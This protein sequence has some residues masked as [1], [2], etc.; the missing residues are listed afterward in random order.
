MFSVCKWN[1][2][3]SFS[4][5]VISGVRQ[6]GVLSAKFW[7]I[8]MND[9]FLKL[10]S[11]LKGCHILNHFLACIL[12][13]DDVC[14]L[15]PTRKAMQRLLD[16]CS[17]YAQSWCIKYN[18][19]KTKMMYFGDDYNTLTCGPLYL[20]GKNLEFVTEWK[21]LGVMVMSNKNFCTSVLKP[22]CAFYRSSNSILNV[23]HGPSEDVQM[24]LLY[25]ICVP[26]IT[27]ACDVVEY[28]SKDKMSLHVALNDA[29]RKIFGYDRWQ[30]IKDI[31]ESFGFPSITEI[32]AKRKSNFELYLPHTGN[33]LLTFLLKI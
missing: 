28:S 11:T 16:I 32:F 19:N 12:Y 17:E 8:Y 25:S 31:R 33:S 2:T 3:V 22:R 1:D 24:K 29:I 30:S 21:Y 7:A 4:F 13:A 5:S 6:G 10:K 9:L 18:A 23:L 15:A 14:L 26:C 27:Y 20:N